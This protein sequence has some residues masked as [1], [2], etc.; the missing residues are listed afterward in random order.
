MHRTWGLRLRRVGRCLGGR[1]RGSF[2]PKRGGEIPRNASEQGGVLQ[3]ASPM[4]ASRRR[5]FQAR[6]QESLARRR[7]RG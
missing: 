2:R 1:G 4:Q 5:V 3:E 7:T 6:G